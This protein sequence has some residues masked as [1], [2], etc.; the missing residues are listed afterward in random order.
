LDYNNALLFGLSAVTLDKL[1][2]VQN[3]AARL[4]TGSGK[5]D[6]ISPHLK[7][8]HWL[9]INRRIDFKMAVLSYKCRA[10]TAPG[11]LQELIAPYVPPR[12]LRSTASLDLVER[13]FK[14]DNYGRRAFS[15]AAH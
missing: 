2:R 8:L 5:R 11:Y 14:T 13:R 10:K 9:P 15:R 7:A 3:A 12:Q 6:H 1:Q 4:L